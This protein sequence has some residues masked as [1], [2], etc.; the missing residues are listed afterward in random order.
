MP[1]PRPNP[2]AQQVA[3]KGF[4]SEGA[5]GRRDPLLPRLPPRELGT[6]SGA[7]RSG[8]SRAS[9]GGAERWQGPSGESSPTEPEV[10]IWHSPPRLPALPDVTRQTEP[11]RARLKSLL[12][13]PLLLAGA[14]PTPA[15]LSPG[16][17][18]CEDSWRGSLG[19]HLG[20]FLPSRFPGVPAPAGALVCPA[21]AARRHG[22]GAEE[23]PVKGSHH[24]AQMILM[25]TE[26]L[27]ES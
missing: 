21:G 24:L 11:S 14:P 17:R 12:L 22:Q 6:A 5:G 4:P 1:R 26:Y 13:P 27:A 9:G 18:E 20:E 7:G 8:D 3:P 15:C 16:S 19:A 25:L 23:S 2:C 10:G